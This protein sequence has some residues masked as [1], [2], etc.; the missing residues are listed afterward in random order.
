MVMLKDLLTE[1]LNLT[2]MY[3]VISKVIYWAKLKATQT[4]I[5]KATLMVI[6]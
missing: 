1:K 6:Y 2:V 4:V 3:L 5:L